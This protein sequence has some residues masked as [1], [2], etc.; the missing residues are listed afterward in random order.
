MDKKIETQYIYPCIKW[1]GGKTL[2]TKIIIP[3]ILE[4]LK[5]KT[6]YVEPFVGGGSII[7]ELLKQ[8]Y[9]NGIT[10]ISFY[11]SDINEVLIRMYNEIKNNPIELIEKLKQYIDK[12]N[13]DDYNRIRNEFNLNPQVEQFIYLNKRCFRGLFRVNKRNEFN[14]SY[15]KTKNPPVF[16]EHN[17]IAL[18]NLFTRYNV[19]FEISNFFER[20]FENCVM[21]LDPPYFE[22]FSEYTICGFNYDEYLKKL[23]EI[24]MNKSIK[25]IH[26][27]SEMFSSIYQSE[28]DIEK[29]FAQDRMN[30]KTQIKLRCEL[31]YS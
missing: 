26:S 27:N 22:T 19:K 15:N 24:R 4:R 13:K 20:K 25:L 29:I 10:N 1:I 12:D 17:I 9:L 14:S 2:Q 21:Y 18:S 31:L 6:V 3:K 28:E 11:C 30:T 7:I 23:K 8:C 16:Q 5:I